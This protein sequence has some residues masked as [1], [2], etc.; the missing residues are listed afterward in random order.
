MFNRALLRPEV[1]KFIRNNEKSDIPGLVLKGSPFDDI[2]V[3]ELA[4]QLKGL[5]IA[6]RKF[7][8]FYQSDEIIYPPSLNLEQ[9][10]SEITAT[11]KA[12][13][14]KGKSCIDLTGG[15]GIDSYYISQ[16]FE[17]F[18]YCELNRELA[19]VAKHNFRS[20]HAN[21]E[22]QHTDSL[23]Y[24]KKQEGFNWIY[25][26]PARRGKTGEKVFRLEDCEPNIPA[27]LDLIFSKTNNLLLK[28]SPILD[29]SAGNRE[30]KFV[31]EI[32]ILAVRNEVKE[33]LWIL[34]KGHEISPVTKCVNFE[35]SEIEKFQGSLD[36]EEGLSIDFSE[37]LEYLYEPNSAIMKSGLFKQLALETGTTKL[38]QHS[39]LYTSNHPL[40]FPGRSFKVIDRMYFKDS[41][42]KKKLKS[43]KANIT[44]RNFPDSVENLRKKFKIKDGGSDYIFFTTN[45]EN[46]KIVIF[47]QKI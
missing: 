24:L 37:P 46:E 19:E 45:L 20:L 2:S 25:A 13:L 16:N 7:P 36:D 42:L 33:L 1:V 6:K 14:V 15:L 21:I 10:S 11:Y 8:E 47:C 41:Y 17:N 35:K 28:T 38:H 31:K 29:I 5:K 18:V 43:R 44:T 34:E 12:S 22:V 9:S 3:Q 32:H 4:G 27:N 23:E 30:L 39:H 26:D 40:K